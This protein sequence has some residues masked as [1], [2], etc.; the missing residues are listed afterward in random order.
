MVNREFRGIKGMD[1]GLS[2][3]SE[4]LVYFVDL[5]NVIR[6]CGLWNRSL[7]KMFEGLL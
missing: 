6:S 1:R 7:I 4:V 2:I 3:K 5:G